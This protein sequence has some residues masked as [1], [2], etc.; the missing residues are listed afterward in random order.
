[1]SK[2]VFSIVLGLQLFSTAAFADSVTCNGDF[3]RF[4]HRW[5]ATKLC[6]RR[7]VVAAAAADGV[8]IARKSGSGGETIE[9]YCREIGHDRMETA[10]YCAAY[11][12]D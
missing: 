8:K 2:F 3:Q 4:G 9:E 1:M 11:S 5:E 10:A 12:P 6:Q 7:A